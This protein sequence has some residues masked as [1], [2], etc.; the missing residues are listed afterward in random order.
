MSSNSH[1]MT[2][3]STTEASSVKPMTTCSGAK[4]G[5]PRTVKKRSNKPAIK[6]RQVKRIKQESGDEGP[7]LSQYEKERLERIARNNALLAALG[8]NIVPGA[9]LKISR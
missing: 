7:P 9:I 6:S 4:V 2:T 5:K 3:R 8:I 1:C